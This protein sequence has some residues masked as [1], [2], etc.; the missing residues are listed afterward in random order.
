[1][2]LVLLSSSSESM[3][4]EL[5]SFERRRA[6]FSFRGV[7][8]IVL[9]LEI[10]MDE[11]LR[12]TKL[13]KRNFLS[14][15]TFRDF[16]HFHQQQ[17]KQQYTH[18]TTPI[19]KYLSQDV[20]INI[21]TTLYVSY[22]KNTHDERTKKEKKSTTFATVYNPQTYTIPTPLQSYTILKSLWPFSILLI[23]YNF[24]QFNLT[25]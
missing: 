6:S 14:I 21:L 23:S 25:H 18:T 1:M 7:V 4:E 9:S 20:Y 5:S 22:Y 13:K 3:M 10:E 19:P 24:I 8:D 2:I 15:Y 16:F 12:E 17:E 11:I